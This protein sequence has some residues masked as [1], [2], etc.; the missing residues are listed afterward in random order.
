MGLIVTA[1][2]L[3]NTHDYAELV[4]K[5]RDV[6]PK[7][8]ELDAAMGARKP[9]TARRRSNGTARSRA[10]AA[11]AGTRTPTRSPRRC[12][13]AIRSAL[14]ML[15]DRK[16]KGLAEPSGLTV[17]RGWA[18]YQKGDWE[19]AKKVFA[20]LQAKQEQ[21]EDAEF[22]PRHDRARRTAAAFVDSDGFGYGA[23]EGLTPCETFQK[24]L[25]DWRTRCR[26]ALAATDFAISVM[27]HLG[28]AAFVLAADRSRAAVEQG[29]RTPD[30]RACARR[31]RHARSLAS[32]LRQASPL[33]RRSRAVATRFDDIG[34]LYV[35][36]GAAAHGGSGLSAETWCAMPQLGRP[37]YLTARRR[38]DLRPIGRR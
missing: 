35:R 31:A 13:P 38:A 1:R 26:R 33:S 34:S 37:L 28:V 3:H 23:T 20:G 12:S 4:A 30:R 27:E 10:G 15:E 6:Y 5:Y 24:R 16:S 11:A 2:R 29:L 14:A 19:G 36:G 21:V 17:V 8:A 32:L 18:L 25:D 7:V 9:P 22:G